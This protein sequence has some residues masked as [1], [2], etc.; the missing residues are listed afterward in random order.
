MKKIIPEKAWK[1]NGVYFVQKN[2]PVQILSIPIRLNSQKSVAIR[3]K[4][5][6]LDVTVDM[7]TLL[8]SNVNSRSLGRGMLKFWA[9]TYLDRR[10][11]SP[12]GNSVS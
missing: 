3:S 11:C 7:I 8:D 5:T 10:H 2:G 12:S 1:L 6:M 4:L 9:L